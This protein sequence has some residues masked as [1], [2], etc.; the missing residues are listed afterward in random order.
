[1]QEIK[2]L[3][4]I[5]TQKKKLWKSVF[6]KILLVISFVGYVGLNYELFISSTLDIDMVYIW[7][8]I[9]NSG[10]VSYLCCRLIN[11]IIS[12]I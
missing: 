3:E 10:V 4:E 6:S 5:Y 1:M 8:S 11:K 7:S 9:M 2:T 12:I